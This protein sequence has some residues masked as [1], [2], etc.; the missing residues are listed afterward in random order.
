MPTL[1][2]N[3]QALYKISEDNLYKT[4]GDSLPFSL[5]L[6]TMFAEGKLDVFDVTGTGDLDDREFVIAA[7]YGLL[8]SYPDEKTI[9]IWLKEAEK[10]N[11]KSAFRKHVICTVLQTEAAKSTMRVPCNLPA[12]ISFTDKELHGTFLRLKKRLRRTFPRL[13]GWL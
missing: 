10:E 6:L 7:Y 9:D 13:F 2:D 4:N 11:D 1:K 12:A 8:G 5:E 3:V